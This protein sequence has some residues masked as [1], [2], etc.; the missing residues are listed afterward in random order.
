MHAGQ[1]LPPTD[2]RRLT[3][4][5]HCH[6]PVEDDSCRLHGIQDGEELLAPG[7]RDAMRGTEVR[8]QGSSWA[9]RSASHPLPNT[10]P[11]AA[12]QCGERHCA[13]QSGWR[14][15]HRGRCGDSPLA[16]T[17]DMKQKHSHD[18]ERKRDPPRAAGS[19]KGY[20]NAG[21]EAWD[22]TSEGLGCELAAV[23]VMKWKE[24]W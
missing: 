7:F 3:S 19:L 4:S 24:D 18:M 10:V 6:L 17:V 20:R 11:P 22:L 23:K 1:A 8:I 9:Q 5:R 21:H 12:H 15:P 16:N 14:Q 2:L 13:A